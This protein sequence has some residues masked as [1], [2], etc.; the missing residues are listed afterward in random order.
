MEENYNLIAKRLSEYMEYKE[1]SHNK[2]SVL[3]P[4]S[5]SRMNNILLKS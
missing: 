1:V 4:T 3:V 5:H 2:L